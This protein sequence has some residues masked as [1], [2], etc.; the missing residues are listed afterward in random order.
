MPCSSSSA[1]ASR[2]SR[3]SQTPSRHSITTI[4]SPPSNNVHPSIGP[5]HSSCAPA[6]APALA[7]TMLKH[8]ATVPTSSPAA[9]PSPSFIQPHACDNC[10]HIH[11]RFYCDPCLTSRIQAHHNE[12]RRLSLARDKAK[13]SLDHIFFGSTHS[14]P[15][16]PQS[17]CSPRDI[18]I[19]I[20]TIDQ[21]TLLPDPFDT[22]APDSFSS[23][24][25]RSD[26]H[27]VLHPLIQLR[28]QRAAII[29]RVQNI[30]Q[31]I[32]ESHQAHLQAKQQLSE[33]LAHIALRKQNL[34]KAWSALEGSSAPITPSA[35]HRSRIA[36]K[37]RWLSH[38]A[39]DHI[40]TP[41]IYTDVYTHYEQQ[42]HDPSAATITPP[43]ESTHHQLGATLTRIRHSIALLHAR[44]T[45]VSTQLAVRRATLARQA[46]DLY[47]ISPPATTSSASSISKPRQV[48]LPASSSVAQRISRLSELYIPGAFG[49]GHANSPSF[50]TTAPSSNRDTARSPALHARRADDNS[51]S[52]ASS[53][54]WSISSL[55]LPLPSEA[56]RYPRDTVNGA[57]THAANL[58][59]LLARYLGVALP[60]AIEQHKGRLAI[61]PDPLWDGGGGSSAKT[62][63]LS[64]SAYAHITAS[65]AA[66]ARASKLNHLAESTIGLGAST[67]STIESYIHLP[68]GTGLPW[69]LASAAAQSAKITS[70]PVNADTDSHRDHD[71]SEA[72]ARTPSSSSSSSR[73]KSDQ[74]AKSFVS[75]LVMLSYNVAY[76]ATKQGIQLDLV[77]AAANPLHL[78]NQI[79][80]QSELGRQAHANYIRTSSIQDLSL[81]SL[82]Y[83]QLAQILEPSNAAADGYKRGAPRHPKTNSSSASGTRQ[84]SARS[85]KPAK[86]L[87]QSYVDVGEAAASVLNIQ[88]PCSVPQKKTQQPSRRTAAP[89][90]AVSDPKVALP[91]QSARP[92][93]VSSLQKQRV[94]ADA[95]GASG[96][97][98]TSAQPPPS[99]DFLRQRGRDASK[100]ENGVKSDSAVVKT[101]QKEP[102]EAQ[103]LEV[104]V[105]PGA[106]IFNGVEVGVGNLEPGRHAASRALSGKSR[107]QSAEE[108]WDL[109]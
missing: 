51:P 71:R 95:R 73:S 6:P 46:F 42:S 55:P 76:L 43:Q 48:D 91:K 36:A 102:S 81:P 38:P 69:G 41:L 31:C 75:A 50:A 17:T 24:S 25:H 58:V 74:A 70:S 9:T 45:A 103:T 20:P 12:M 106:V 44:A 14:R 1:F 101:E 5:N 52:S 34:A 7:R 93:V 96:A 21:S 66:A 107:K 108:G 98:A 63:Y 37:S 33:K 4:S 105:G 40:H 22:T 19:N 56:R 60:F 72:H 64:S 54:N 30:H 3:P 109:L 86:I 85:L 27:L 39:A 62:L 59:Q 8:S 28:A 2:P 32:C 65:H 104:K 15:H 13:A 83:E 10:H 11:T 35:A 67:L 88:D 47:N 79:V 80:H 18:P 77:A 26:P 78:L 82:D 90:Q 100:A 87:E 97:S 99:L 92:D 53:S 23:S 49:L 29:S 68:S 94:G 16:P 89:H 61:R 84:A 57:V